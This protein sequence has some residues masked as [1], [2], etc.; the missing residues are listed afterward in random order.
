VTPPALLRFVLEL[1]YDGAPFHGW[2]LQ[3]HAPTVQGALEAALTRISAGARIPVTGSGRTDR[4]VHATGQVAAVQLP[5]SWTAPELRK[6][7]NALLPSSVWV[8]RAA[9]APPGFHPRFDARRRSYEYRV[10]VARHCHSPFLRQICWP[11]TRLPP[12]PHLLAEAA[13]LLPGDRS[14]KSFARAG[15]EE[16]GDR[17]HVLSADWS[18]WTGFEGEPLGWRFRIVAN[19]YLHHMV[20]YLVG[21]QVAVARGQRPMA[22]L[23]RLLE[24]PE[25]GLVTS[26]PAPP[27]GL[28]LAQVA[29]DKDPFAEAGADAPEPAE[30]PRRAGRPPGPSGASPSPSDPPSR[31]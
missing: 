9:V 4:G 2:Q 21:T 28:F 7:L 20:R 15:Q 12:D 5:A 27:E 13:A 3:P 14:W 17:C 1:H 18:P 22:E 11:V 8:S 31:P 6:A 10:G 16:R 25:C 23:A 30:G 26:P 19:R 24:D 29:Y